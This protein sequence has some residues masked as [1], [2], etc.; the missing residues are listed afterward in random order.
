[1]IKFAQVMII[2]I[3]APGLRVGRRDPGNEVAKVYVQFKQNEQKTTR[4]T[5]MTVSYYKLKFLLK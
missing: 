4:K 3:P 5:D 1:M 2:L